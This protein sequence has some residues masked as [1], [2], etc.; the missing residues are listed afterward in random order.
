MSGET[1][2]VVEVGPR[3][4]LQ[5]RGVSLTVDQRVEW[6]SR[7]ISAGLGEIEAG[8]FVREDRVPSMAASDEVFRHCSDA[9]LLHLWAL[10][11]NQRGALRA[12]EAGASSFAFFTSASESF[13][14]ANSRCSIEESLERFQEVRQTTGTAPLRTY[15]SCSFGCP[16][17]G[18]IAPERVLEVALA[19]LQA[20]SDELV[21][22]DT[23]GIATAGTTTALIDRLQREIPLEKLSLHLHD[24]RGSA[25]EC[26]RAGLD[27]GIRGFDAS[28]GGIGGCPFAPGARGNIATEDLLQL[29][30]EQ[31]HDSGI[32]RER[33][34]ESSLWLERCLGEQLPA[35]SLTDR[36]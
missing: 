26:A 13:S 15:L 11:P 30:A 6:I 24:T 5:S 22:S 31:G 32:D 17:E 12:I 29:L 34:I 36:R 18:E 1:V 4:G 3:D 20:G 9:P 2:R 10:I 8:S 28:A 27:S 7:L 19:L 33:L 21:I 23:I 16:Y 35:R 25:L 14:E